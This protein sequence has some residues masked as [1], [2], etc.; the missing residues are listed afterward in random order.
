MAVRVRGETGAEGTPLPGREVMAS[1]RD[2]E[3]VVAGRRRKRCGVG[4]RLHANC[5]STKTLLGARHNPQ[6]HHDLVAR[7]GGYG[8]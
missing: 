3:G 7:I 5:V 2:A 4:G 8:G 1:D 6:N